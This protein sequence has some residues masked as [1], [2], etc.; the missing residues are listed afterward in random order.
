VAVCPW[1]VR[2]ADALVCLSVEY[3]FSGVGPFYRSFDQV[4]DEEVLTMLKV[5]Q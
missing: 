2:G 3:D 5:I 4:E 1:G